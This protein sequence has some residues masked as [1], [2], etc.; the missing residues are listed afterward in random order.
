MVACKKWASSVGARGSRERAPATT[1]LGG[2]LQERRRERGNGLRLSRGWDKGEGKVHLKRHGLSGL[3]P[4]D[5]NLPGFPKL[6][7]ILPKKR[8][9]VLGQASPSSRTRLAFWPA[10][11][12]WPFP[13]FAGVKGQGAIQ[14]LVLPNL[15]PS[16]LRASLSALG[17]YL[18]CLVSICFQQRL[19]LPDIPRNWP[20]L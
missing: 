7:P 1:Y 8:L 11:C 13:V 19:Y 20:R 18:L 16:T 12:L 17:G 2:V 9:L 10:S 3:I 5:L 6:G 14:P 4:R 15:D